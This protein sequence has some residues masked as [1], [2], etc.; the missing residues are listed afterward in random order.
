MQAPAC[1]WDSACVLGEGPIWDE[2]GQRLYFVDIEGCAL[3]WRDADGASGRLA[4]DGRLCAVAPRAIGGLIAATPR[5]IE[6]L[7]PDTGTRAL[8][9]ALEP[10]RPGNRPNDGK[11]DP[12]GR[13]WVGTMDDTE[14]DVSG[15]LHRVSATGPEQ[16]L[17][18]IGIANGL[19]WSPDGRLM[20]FTDSMRSTI[21]RFAFEPTTGALSARSVFRAVPE[22]E[23]WPDGLC[24]DAEGFVWSAHWDGARVTR[25]AP[26]G[27][28]DCVIALPVPRVT[29][30]CFGG[31][32]LDTLFITTA[33]IG[34]DDEALAQAPL[35]G[36][37]FALKPGVRGQGGGRVKL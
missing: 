10:D 12:Q 29:S 18:D 30:C 34:L 37:L 32:E 23:G 15:A 16:V 17:G 6:T 14:Q 20:Y 1:V 27:T 4:I 2:A 24:V 9:F 3:L 21:W 13:F 22:A 7:D 11:C 19:G 26:D 36:G 8:L 5:G 33:R 28:I 35:S 31:A 25:Y